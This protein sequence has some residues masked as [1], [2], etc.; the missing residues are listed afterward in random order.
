[1]SIVIVGAGP[2]LGL[3][4][5]RRFGSEGMPV[6]LVSRDQAKLDGLVEQL[7]EDGIR[8]SS[9]AADIREPDALVAGDPGPGGPARRGRGARV[10]AAPRPR[11]HEADP[12]D[13]RRRHPRPA[14][15]QH[16]RRRRRGPGGARPDARGRPRLDPLHH[17]HRLHHPQPRARRGRGLVLGRGRLRPHAPRGPRRGGH[18]RRPHRHPRADRAGRGVRAGRDRRR[19]CGGTTASAATSRPASGSRPRPARASAASRGAWAGTSCARRAA[20]WWPAAGRRG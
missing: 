14:R 6:G 18:P 3:A 15:V 13:H 11:V 1:M 16:R 5:G 10:L 4:I 19:C 12:R 7:E 2:N 8:A 9:E 20:S 17:R